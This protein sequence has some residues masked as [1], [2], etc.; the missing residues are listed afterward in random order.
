MK[1]TTLILLMLVIISTAFIAGCTQ[2]LPVPA[3]SSTDT[4][5]NNGKTG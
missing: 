3:D 2:Q 5:T 4:A 1:N